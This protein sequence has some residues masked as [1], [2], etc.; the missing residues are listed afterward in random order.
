[1]II[2]VFTGALEC[3]NNRSAGVRFWRQ[4]KH[5][6]LLVAVVLFVCESLSSLRVSYNSGM[7]ASCWVVD[8]FETFLHLG[9]LAISSD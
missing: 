8:I 2:G 6:Y 5:H 4:A 9:M 7:H 3:C 1:M